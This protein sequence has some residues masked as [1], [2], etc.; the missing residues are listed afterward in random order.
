[1]VK[2]ENLVSVNFLKN[3]TS[4]GVKNILG[5]TPQVRV[6]L[7]PSIGNFEYP[8]LLAQDVVELSPAAQNIAKTA[9]NPITSKK[10]KKAA[11]GS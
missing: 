11:K 4:F 7:K 10:N 1:M 5:H 6:P 9:E 8:R 2:V 3:I